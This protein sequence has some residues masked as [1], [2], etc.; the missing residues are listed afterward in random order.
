[1]KTPEKSKG[2]RSVRSTWTFKEILLTL[3][4]LTIC[5][6]SVAFFTRTGTNPTLVE[7]IIDNIKKSRALSSDELK[8]LDE[9]RMLLDNG[10]PAEAIYAYI[11]HGSTYSLDSS[12]YPISGGEKVIVRIGEADAEIMDDKLSTDDY[13]ATLIPVAEGDKLEIHVSADQQHERGEDY[14]VAETKFHDL[15]TVDYH[16]IY[17][18]G[19]IEITGSYRY[20]ESGVN[21]YSTGPFSMKRNDIKFIVVSDKEMAALETIRKMCETRYCETPEDQSN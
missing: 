15:S 9:M 17:N 4:V 18:I 5:A 2:S 7:T 19:S 1:M 12:L 10:I 11:L 13:S 14:A 3:F 21:R 20:V 8:S 16:Q 6:T